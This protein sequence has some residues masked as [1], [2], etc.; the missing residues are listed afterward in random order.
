MK[1]LSR[2]FVLVTGMDSAWGDVETVVRVSWRVI[3]ELH[4]G[5]WREELLG[6]GCSYLPP[7]SRLRVASSALVVVSPMTVLFSDVPISGYPFL[8]PFIQD[9]ITALLVVSGRV[10]GL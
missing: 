3:H 9:K 4:E 1:L 2:M 6:V 8:D 7:T 10:R 5:A